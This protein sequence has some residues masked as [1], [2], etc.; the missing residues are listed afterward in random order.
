MPGYPGLFGIDVTSDP[1]QRE[2]ALQASFDVVAEVLSD[3]L[4]ARELAKA[5]KIILANQLRLEIEMVL[6]VGQHG[7][8]CSREWCRDPK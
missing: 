6:V 7:H 3:G 8:Q 1:N 5:K 4:D 2:K